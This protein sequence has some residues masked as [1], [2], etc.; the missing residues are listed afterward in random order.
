MAYKFSMVFLALQKEDGNL[1]FGIWFLDR[2]NLDYI[3]SHT[4]L[5]IFPIKK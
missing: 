5:I 1:K 2:K 4:I 3:C